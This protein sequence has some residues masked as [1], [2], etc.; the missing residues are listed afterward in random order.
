LGLGYDSEDGIRTLLGY[1]H[2]NLFRRAVATRFDLRLS[3]RERQARLLVR[4]PFMGRLR[5]P[6]T[7]SLFRVEQNEQS[8]DSQ[9]QGFQV[10]TELSKGD[11]KFG[12]LLTLK[13]VR[14]LAPDPALE[15]LEIDRNLREIDISSLTPRLFVDRR[16]DP[17]IPTRGWTAGLQVEY[18]FPSFGGTAEFLKLF[19]QQT[20]YL[21]LGRLGVV[22]GS[23]RIGAIEPLGSLASLDPTVPGGLESANVPISERFFA[24]G[25][26]THRAYRRDLLGVLGETL[27]QVENDDGSLRRVPIG[28]NGLLLANLDYRFPIA[29]AVGGTVFFD[30]GNVFGEWTGIDLSELEYGAGVGLRYVS[31]LGPLRLEVGWKLE[32]DADEKGAVIFLSFGN[33]F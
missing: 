9:R 22:A 28:G 12:L 33:P 18:A 16:D 8:F 21:D 11:A 3:Q 23:F 7:Y 25:R 4:K 19:G 29:G 26:T 14:V 15:A 31:P 6:I 17:L 13:Q 32:R 10:D 2:S 20:S 1:S 30:A 24:G 5:A 27:L